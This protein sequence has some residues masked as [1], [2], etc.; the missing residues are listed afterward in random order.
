MAF[1][2]K[3]SCHLVSGYLQLTGS[4]YLHL[5]DEVEATECSETFVSDYN[6]SVLGKDNMETAHIM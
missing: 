1:W 5:Q 3:M 6:V 4:C 2:D